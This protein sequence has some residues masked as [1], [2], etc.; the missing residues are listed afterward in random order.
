MSFHSRTLKHHSMSN[1]RDFHSYYQHLVILSPLSLSL[2]LAWRELSLSHCALVK[3]Y[4]PQLGKLFIRTS[5]SQRLL[6]IEVRFNSENENI[7]PN[8][9]FRRVK[10]MHE[11]FIHFFVISKAH[12]RRKKNWLF[13]YPSS[14][15][16]H[17]KVMGF[18]RK[19][20][21]KIE[22]RGEKRRKKRKTVFHDS[23]LLCV[24]HEHVRTVVFIFD[25]PLLL[26]VSLN[27]HFIAREKV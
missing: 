20:R 18:H 4:S 3:N 8:T 1:R 26:C 16:P 25:S 15:I 27:S 17:S 10:I 2:S 21:K 6:T 11:T 22:K 23:L 5:C 24:L 9:L 12:V 7:S 14:H 13:F 19:N